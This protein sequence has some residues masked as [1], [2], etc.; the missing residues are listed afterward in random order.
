[1]TGPSDFG[2]SAVATLAHVADRPFAP[3]H[4]PFWARWRDDV[5]SLRPRLVPADP[6]DPSDSAATHRFESLGSARIGC[7]I[8]LPPKGTPV[9]AGLIA[10]HGYSSCEPLA[11]S[12]RRWGPLCARGVAVLHLRVRGFPGSQ[13]DTGDW[14]DDRDGLGWI[15]HGFPPVLNRPEDA[16]HWS[17]PLAVA[18]IACAGRA[19]RDWLASRAGADGLPV[20]ISLHGESFGAGLAVLA[21]AQTPASLVSFERLAIG[22]PTFGDWAWRLADPARMALGA[23]AHLL[24]L[25]RAL[26]SQDA[27]D[28]LRLCDAA[29]HAAQVR[30]PTLCKLA[31]RDEMVPAPS[32][33]AVYNALGTDPGHKW[34]FLVPEAHTEPSLAGARRH[35]LFER[36][37]TDFL[38]PAR[39][40]AQAMA[41]WEPL[42]N[43]GDHAP[44]RE[45]APLTGPQTGLFADGPSRDPLDD[46]LVAAYE[47]AGRTLDDLPYTPEWAA[48]FAEVEPGTGLRERE[49]FHRLHNL[50]KAGKLP[51]MGRANSSPPTI[52]RVEEADLA[53]R[54]TRLVGSLG[55]RDRLPFTPEFDRLVLEFNTATGRNL[56]PHDVWRLVAKLAK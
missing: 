41:P 22:V 38:D 45:D 18:D 28:T 49:A 6:A 13:L 24:A 9:S 55:Q 37:A 5:A 54:V 48:L 33:A 26:G 34:R 27:I 8:E 4:R 29:A 25:L 19:L 2:L 7:A 32:A 50:R 3:M 16:M 35:S 12:V 47:R 20:T 15:A 30:L 39:D 36:C 42:L 46:Q 21:A 10:T 1:M 17:V 53:G 23:G 43:E 51:R 52:D 56:G 14:A 44:T 11:K 31:L 40:P